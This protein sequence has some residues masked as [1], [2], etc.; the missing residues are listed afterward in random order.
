[1]VPAEF[2][3]A[4]NMCPSETGCLAG[5]PV[6]RFPN[7]D[8]TGWAN[9]LAELLETEVFSLETNEGEGF[10]LSTAPNMFT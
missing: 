2:G 9:I 10:W 7:T 6:V 3:V 4:P 1:M 5:D 8:V